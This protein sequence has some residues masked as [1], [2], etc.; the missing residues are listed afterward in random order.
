MAELL[1]L[2]FG[3]LAG[4]G[5]TVAARSPAVRRAVL[6]RV[7]SQV[8]SRTGVAFGAS[9]FRFDPGEGRLEIDGLR[10]GR[11]GERPALT[12]RRA[13]VMLRL[14]ELRGQPRRLTSVELDR[15]VVDL[16]AP[17]PELAA[18]EGGDGGGGIEI[19]RFAITGG[20]L[21][22]LAFEPGGVL[23]ALEAR[24]IRAVGALTGG[25][26]T[27]RVLRSAIEV[28][29]ERLGDRSATLR[30]EAR[31]PVGGPWTFEEVSLE[32]AGFSARLSGQAGT[33]DDAPLTVRFAAEGEAEGLLPGRG[34]A[35]AWRADGEV[36]LAAAAGRLEIDTREVPFDPVARLLFDDAPPPP[37]AGARLDLSARLELGPGSLGRVQGEVTAAGS[38]GGRRLFGLEATPRVSG[39]ETRLPLDLRLLPDGRGERRVSGT[40]VA[41]SLAEL[42]GA[43]WEN[44]RARLRLPRLTELPGQIETLWP[45]LA[46]PAAAADLDRLGASGA[47][48]LDATFDGPLTSPRVSLDGSI[49]ARG[50]VVRLRG[51]GRPAEGIGRL[52][53]EARG[54]ELGALGLEGLTGTLDGALVAS[55]P[56]SSEPAT[57]DADLTALGLSWGEQPTLDRLALVAESRGERLRVTRVEAVRGE[58]SVRV[59]GE[60]LLAG[61]LAPPVVAGE[62]TAAVADPRLGVGGAVLDGRLAGGLLSLTV[63]LD[64]SGAPA[65]VEAE[66][67]LAVLGP[68][69]DGWVAQP[70]AGAVSLRWRLAPRDWAPLLAGLGVAPPERLE[71][72]S[73]G[74]LALDPERPLE[75]SGRATI[76]ALAVRSGALDLSAPGPL[77]LAV[78]DGRL[79]LAPAV[80]QVA[81]EEVALGGSARLLDE[82]VAVVLDPVGMAECSGR[83]EGDLP[84][85]G[86]GEMEVSLELPPCEVGALATRLLELEKPIE[87]T[88]GLT[89]RARLD[90]ASPAAATARLEV[91]GLSGALEGRPIRQLGPLEA[92]LA[93]GRL[94]VP[95]TTLEL[96]GL[97]L[98][99]D[100]T[101]ELDPEWT[102][103]RPPVRSLAAHARGGLEARLLTPLLA[104]G[105]ASGPLALELDLEGPPDALAG[106]LRVDGPEVSILY[107]V[108]YRTLI[109]SPR[110][111]VAFEQGAFRLDGSELRLNEGRVQLLGGLDSAG[112]ADLRAVL[113]EVRYRLDYGLLVTLGG[114]LE[115][116]GDP[117]GDSTLS[118]SI[119]VA[120]GILTRPIELD[121]EFLTGLLS[122]VDL[123]G[124]SGGPLEQV[125]LDL[126]VSTRE[127]VRVRNN[128][129]DLL[130]LWD[131]L[132]VRGNLAIPRVE[133]RL[134]VQPG[135]LI[136]A[137][138]QT[139]RL[140]RASITYSGRPGEPPELDFATTTTVDEP[141]FSRETALAD[142]AALPGDAEEPLAGLS[143]LS[144]GLALFYGE[145]VA[146]RVG[147][148]LG[149]T[150][151]SLRPIPVFGETDPA[152]RLN[153][154]RDF[155]RRISV[156][157]SVDLREAEGQTY[158]LDLHD[159]PY[160]ER[161]RTQLFTL[162]DGTEGA[163]VTQT[164]RLGGRAPSADPR[165]RELTI[166]GRPPGVSRRGLKRALRLDE[167]DPLGAGDRFAA[168]VDLAEYLR[169][170]GYPAARV[171]VTARASERAEHSV[172]LAVAIDAGVRV[173]FRFDG[174]RP[175]ERLRGSIRTLY[176]ADLWEEASLE[177]MRQQTIR[178]FRS[179]GYLEPEVS[180]EV[181][182]AAVGEPVD[183]WVVV[184]TR[185]GER[186]EPGPPLFEGVPPEESDF[187]AARFWGPVQRTELA[188][189]LPDADRRAREALADLGYPEAEIVDRRLSP[190]GEE[191]TVTVR[192]GRRQVVASLEVQGFDGPL[193]EME[194]LAPGDPARVDRIAAAA[195]RLRRELESRGY[196]DARTWARRQPL[197]DDPFAVAVVLEVEAGRR[198]RFGD[199][200]F[201]G[202]GST[203]PGWARSVAG[204]PGGD[205]FLEEQ[206]RQAR[207]RLYRTGLFSAVGARIERPEEGELASVVF[208]VE[209]RPRYQ[210]SYGL[211]WDTDD[212]ASL[213]V[214]ATDNNLFGRGIQL[215]VRALASEK[216]AS[217]RTMLSVPRFLGGRG[218]LRWFNLLR[219]EVDELVPSDLITES[220]EST[221]Q[222]DHPLGQNLRGRVYGSWLDTRVREEEP[223]PFFPLDERLQSPVLG[224]QLLY[225][226]RGAALLP[227]RGVFASL[228]LSGSGEFLASD[229]RYV[230]SFAQVHL[231]HQLAERGRR[232]VVWAQSWRVGAAEAFNQRLARDRFFAGGPFSVRGYPTESLGPSETLAGNRVPTG[233]EALLVLNQELRV[234][235]LPDRLTTLLFFDAGNVWERL[236]TVDDELFQSAGVG[237]RAITPLG[238]L[239]LDV[240][241]PLDRREEDSGFRLH[242]GFGTLF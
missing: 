84:R 155:T 91:T 212:A 66:I 180:V 162:D 38:R 154:S 63:G 43:T 70:A 42:G 69:A 208:D 20:Q 165:I 89:A 241:W 143:G 3:G 226:T 170:R 167:G 93:G 68:P 223:D 78:D 182:P 161:L 134:E 6:E 55:R 96:G 152:A 216:D 111:R 190:G 85:T 176:R 239:R 90:P 174:A 116:R 103:G 220:F 92:R 87:I 25:R 214:D 194:E 102:A 34:L 123:T 118:G 67:P 119:R 109:E 61:P 242:F 203:R 106:S 129:A 213:L 98:T 53:A 19:G 105:A 13:T 62:L 240:A 131:P 188:A 122:P 112:R 147:E 202:L 113:S 166:E 11:P 31:G 217:F 125:A 137:P 10:L 39:E 168:E 197:P 79:E 237:F 195:T 177:E 186:I 127:G 199:V 1:L 164:L 207:R 187:V 18:S 107:P 30:G 94:T 193:P 32:S 24:E 51:S 230:R 159:L 58:T 16:S 222:Y 59:A 74:S 23:E 150:E 110:L 215:G 151:I 128:L 82:R 15:P 234:T 49:T 189:G 114:T 139:L 211:R 196:P 233:G 185:P 224:G 169:G 99:F 54:F 158:I 231:F 41:P 200:G 17:L 144:Q 50:G 238:M 46:P 56:G 88:A 133:G 175:P 146:S 124:T 136:Y 100:A 228:D 60:L 225:N 221:L 83:L 181:L 8:E 48:A 121:R 130:V 33:G 108:P 28:G 75:A 132:S 35:G 97:P 163:T 183:R 21:L 72:A 71:L 206:M 148:T 14:K 40:L 29:S 22:G 73:R 9:D 120:R 156:V 153:I 86:E 209:E 157:A 192:P 52:A 138:G 126:E 172:D 140:E 232:A 115:W 205:L 142:S 149:G 47:V 57:L 191:L 229:F 178:V 104:G 145:Q 95:E 27:A 26:L 37:L 160:V 4:L 65:E 77:E 81:G 117:A 12:A 179:Q 5:A 76:E 171:T 7:A 36:D 210:L 45:G 198:F 64:P 235:V 135:G 80:L 2:A 204:L 184:T 227:R 101:A 201:E 173:G 218:E 219:R 44:G 141:Q 236:D